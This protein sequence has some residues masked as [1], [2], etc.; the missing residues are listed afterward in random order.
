MRLEIAP[1]EVV[2]AILEGLELSIPLSIT[3]ETVG[4]R[5]ATFRAWL[6][7]G[8]RNEGQ[9]YHG[10]GDYCPTCRAMWPDTCALLCPFVSLRARVLK[11]RARGCEE[12]ISAIRLKAADEKSG[13]RVLL[14]LARSL[15]PDKIHHPNGSRNRAYTEHLLLGGSQAEHR[16]DAEELAIAQADANVARTLA[17]TELANAQREQLGRSGSYFDKLIVAVSGAVAGGGDDEPTIVTQHEL[18]AASP[19]AALDGDLD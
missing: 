15:Y 8:A 18:E 5:V 14:E 17:Q 16:D 6:A 9:G 4:V 11:S 13:S 12:L 2:E 3:L 7:R 10:A 19:S 1:P